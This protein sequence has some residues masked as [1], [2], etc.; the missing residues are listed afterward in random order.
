MK[1]GITSGVVY[2]HAICELARKYR[3]KNIGGTSAGAIAAAF[4]AAAEYHRAT[5]PAFAGGDAGYLRL[6]RLPSFL[7]GNSN[8]FKLFR[9]ESQVKTHFD[10]VLAVMEIWKAAGAWRIALAPLRFVRHFL[11][12]FLAGAVVALL[13]VAV[14]LFS[15]QSNP[16]H[17]A[18]PALLVG[19]I[20]ATLFGLVST[21]LYAGWT[22]HRCLSESR[23]GFCSGHSSLEPPAGEPP[24]LTDWLHREIQA[25]AGL[26]ARPRSCPLSFGDLAEAGV[27]LSV[28]TTDLSQRRPFELSL[29]HE[30]ERNG[31]HNFRGYYFKRSEFSKL[32]PLDVVE[33]MVE[34]SQSESP[35]GAWHDGEELLEWPAMR[36]VPIVVA[37]RLS[38]SFPLLLQA[39]PLYRKDPTLRD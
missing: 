32:F 22:G 35:S 38:L 1:G 29:S 18:L 7:A 4:A 6:S 33:T 19:I 2:P 39:V 21:V 13:P 10:A 11:F 12:P 26:D 5:T 24:A 25:L 8:L 31:A 3:L 30:T 16:L 36:K 37:A 34:A 23:F 27:Q 20:V 15:S 14:L 17:Y 28:M 9:P